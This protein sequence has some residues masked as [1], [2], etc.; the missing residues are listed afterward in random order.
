MKRVRV[1]QITHDLALGGLQRVVLN[2]CNTIDRERFEVSVL[3]LRGLG[4]FAPEI[5]KGGTKVMLVPQVQGRAD[6]FCFVKVAR[7]LRD[8]RIDVIHT[9]NTQPF[10]DGTMGAMISGVRTVVHTDHSRLFP[11][12]RRYMLMERVM[13]QYAFKVVGVSQDTSRNL[14]R[15]ERIPRSKIVTIVNGIDESLFA[16]ETDGAGMRNELGIG[17]RGPVIGFCGRLEPQKGVCY[18]LEALPQVLKRLP[19]A[20]LVIVG[21]GYFQD[22]LKHQAEALGVEKSVIFV[23]TRRDMPRV[24][25]ALD[26]LVLPSL[27]EGMPMVLLEAM[28]S[29]CPVVAT[30]VGGVR[31]LIAHGVSGSVVEPKNAPKLGEELIRLLEDEE[32]R[33]RYVTNGLRTVRERFSIAS[34]TK[35]YERLYL[36]ES[37]GGIS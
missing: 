8:E 27:F 28:A 10:L 7:I 13:A 36:R 6:Y 34:M 21:D 35:R 31:E 33:L 2:I 12:K 32:M 14:E 30:D 17:S 24:Y 16:A 37:E 9:H 5:E 25:K 20:A 29:G 15:Y 19:D 26:V 23:G 11:D 1:M 18:L 22:D 4:M 3:C